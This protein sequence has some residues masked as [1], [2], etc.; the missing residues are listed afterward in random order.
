MIDNK[1]KDLISSLGVDVELDAK[2]MEKD[3]WASNMLKEIGKTVAPSGM[4]YKGSVAI[5]YYVQ[6]GAVTKDRYEMASIAQ[7]NVDDMSE[8]LTLLGVNNTVVELRKHY[9]R[10]NSTTRP[11]DRR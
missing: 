9:G 3:P 1:P 2:A 7:I 6:E 11:G 5:H 8:Q 4:E 10:K